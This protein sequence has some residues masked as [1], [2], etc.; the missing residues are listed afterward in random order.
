MAF[1]V[2]ASDRD[3]PDDEEF[4]SEDDDDRDFDD[5]LCNARVAGPL[6]RPGLSH[7]SFDLLLITNFC[8]HDPWPIS[9]QPRNTEHTM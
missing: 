1:A 9:Q 7:C 8:D 2:S 5:Y 4:D 6:N 3:H